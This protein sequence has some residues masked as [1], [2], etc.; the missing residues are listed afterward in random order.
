M[1]TARVAWHALTHEA[2]AE[3]IATGPEGLDS[4]AVAARLARYGPNR[5]AS[6][7]R[8]GPL[9]RFFMQFHNILLYVMMGAAVVTASLGE[10]VDSGVLLGAVVINAII[11]FIQEGRAEAALDAIR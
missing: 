1:E 4:Q 10:W 7:K 2:V 9:R 6:A 8:H 3:R 5:L 11:G